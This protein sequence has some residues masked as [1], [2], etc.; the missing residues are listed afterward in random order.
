M[1]RKSVCLLALGAGCASRPVAAPTPRSGVVTAIAPI[2]SSVIESQFSDS[3]KVFLA[4]VS[5]GLR[6][7]PR[8]AGRWIAGRLSAD[9]AAVIDLIARNQDSVRCLSAIRLRSFVRLG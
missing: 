3:S 5:I 1:L 4:A 8:D 9:S 6:R 7:A 2:W